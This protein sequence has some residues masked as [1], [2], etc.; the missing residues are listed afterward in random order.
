[1]IHFYYTYEILYKKKMKMKLNYYL[2]FDGSY[3]YQ[4]CGTCV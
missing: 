3:N 4:P 1:M 2:N